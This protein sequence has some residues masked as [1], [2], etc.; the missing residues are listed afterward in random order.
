[1]LARLVL[2]ADDQG[3]E[4]VGELLE[5]W[6][7]IAAPSWTPWTVVQHRSVLDRHLIPRLGDVP[8]RHLGVHDVDVL[9]SQLRK[10]GGEGGGPLTPATVRRIHAVLRRALQQALRWGWLTTNPAALATLPKITA[11]EIVPPSSA[12]VARLLALAET[13]DLDFHCYLRVAASTGA[14]RSQMCGL[15]WRDLDLAGRSILFARGIVDGPN[16]VVLKD[17]KSGRA[18]RAA[19]D[20]SLVELLTKHRARSEARAAAGGVEIVT[21]GFVFSYEADASRP[22]RPDGVTNRFGRLRRAA[23]LESVRLHDLRHYVATAL[24]AAGVPVTTVAGRLGHARAS[25][26]LNVY[27]HFV[28]AT[29]HHAAD[30]LGALLTSASA[31]DPEERGAPR[32]P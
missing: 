29:D 26:T 27:A 16:G 25:T 20:D 17:T 9:Y 10:G 11:A 12:D 14:R 6:F 7:E 19:I 4:T 30:V 18:Y 5:R 28:A 21:S 24:L 23:G 13:E 1:E 32:S 3:S 31:P 8:V 22:W 15:Q 2:E